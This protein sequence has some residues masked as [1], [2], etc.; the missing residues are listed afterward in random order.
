MRQRMIVFRYI[1]IL[2]L[3]ATFTVGN[4]MPLFAEVIEI[5]ADSMITEVCVFPDS[6][7]LTR[8]VPLSLKKGE[9]KIV[10][11]D[12]IPSVDKNS[13]KVSSSAK[14]GVILY[15]A[16]LKKEFVEDLPSERLNE[17][18]KQRQS[19][20]NEIKALK[21][22][23]ALLKEEKNFLDSLRLFSH[24]QIPRD[25]ATRMPLTSDLDGIYKFLD[26][27]LKNYYLQSRE[28]DIDIRTKQEQL[29][30]L[31]Q[32]INL[33]KGPMRKMRRSI[34]VEFELQKQSQ[35]EILVSYIVR[36]ASWKPVYD[37]RAS[38]ENSKVDLVSHGLIVQKTGREMVRPRSTESTGRLRWRLLSH[39]DLIRRQGIIYGEAIG[40]Q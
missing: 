32:N 4:V 39:L 29:R 8:T 1:I 11:S 31:I 10:L 26:E 13:L 14:T 27:K 37:A 24:K 30:A 40:W 23:Q 36:G 28:T 22:F 34:V 19:L 33:I 17:L 5:E 7:L 3:T 9:Y 25:L 12:I 15:G 35:F 20:E 38:F 21:D 6:A 2:V 16:Q 18:E